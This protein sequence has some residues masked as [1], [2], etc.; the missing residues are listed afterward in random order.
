MNKIN[1]NGLN[2]MAMNLFAFDSAV[3]IPIG[4]QE[5]TNFKQ[6][7]KY[8]G[9]YN[10]SQ[11]RLASVVSKK[12][13]IIQ[14]RDVLS[15]VTQTLG[16]LNLDV[17]GFVKCY[18][19]TMQADLVFKDEGF[20]MK[21]DATG[22]MLGFRVLNS[23]DKTTSFRLEAYAYR[24]VCENGMAFGNVL[25]TRTLTFHTGQL[26]TFELI[27]DITEKFITQMIQHQEKLQTLVNKAIA[28]SI[29]WEQL[30]Q[31]LE[32][33]MP[34]AKHKKFIAEKLAEIAPNGNFTRWQL[35]NV[36]TD[37]ASHNLELKQGAI[38][39]LEKMSQKIIEKPLEIEVSQ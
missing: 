14:H 3:E 13:Q 2:D 29:A 22:I 25:E 33:L 5:G 37:Y 30:D 4:Y 24:L 9:I 23:Y 20:K 8:K 35:Y 36:V 39:M 28:D 12:Y 11:E 32:K 1:V 15:A 21:D 18:N 34:T 19:E 7:S 17:S 31:I 38:N 10:V 6:A 27:Q 16:K 26:K